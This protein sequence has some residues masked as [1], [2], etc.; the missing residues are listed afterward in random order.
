M[1]H[2]LVEAIQNG[3]DIIRVSGT[4]AWKIVPGSQI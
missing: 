1:M 2:V 3:S 4:Q